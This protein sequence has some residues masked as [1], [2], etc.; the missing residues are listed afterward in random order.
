MKKSILFMAAIVVS[1]GI[2]L[3][4]AGEESEKIVIALKTD[5]FEIE[6]TDLS[7]LAVGDA[8]TIVTESGRTIDMLRAEDGIEIYVDGELLEMGDMH[9]K[10]HQVHKIRIICD[11]GEEDCDEDMTWISESEDFD[12]EAIH[13]DGGKFIIVQGDDEDWDVEVL[14][15]GAHEVHGELHEAGEHEVIIIKKK[16]EDEI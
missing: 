6:K 14:E 5:D 3:A 2:N 1:A 13:K 11:E 15:D 12:V 8:E 16:V 10:H 4:V 7:H 9:A